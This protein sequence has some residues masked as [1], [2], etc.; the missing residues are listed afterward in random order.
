M[1][2]P[3]ASVEIAGPLPLFD[4]SVEAIQEAG[5]LHLEE[6]P[7]LEDGGHAGLHRIRLSEAQERDRQS[8][9][10]TLRLLEEGVARIPVSLVHDLHGSPK[11]P[12]EYRRWDREN[13]ATLASTVRVLHAKVR[14]QIRRERNLADDLQALSVYEEVSA[15]LAP[16]VDGAALPGELEFVGVV[17]E[18]EARIAADLLEKEVSALSAGRSR[19]FQSV[20][21]GGRVAALVGF[22]RDQEERVRAFMD[23]SGV[24]P[25]AMPRYLR[26]RP[27]EQAL[28]ALAADLAGLRRK[29]QDLAGQALRFYE[30]SG[31]QLLALRDL[32]RDRRTRYEA[33][34]KFA[35]TTYTFLL[36]GWVAAADA[37]RLG[38][39]LAQ[40]AGRAVI[41]RRVRPKGMG[42]PP[43]LL[44][45]P[46]P[47]RSFEPLLSFLPLPQY[48]SVDPT[49]FIA[50]F[51][52]PIFGMMLGDIGYGAILGA[53]AALLWVFGR[54]RP[55]GAAA[56]RTLGRLAVVLAACAFFTVV[57]G[58]VFGELFGSLGHELGLKPLWME[59][60]PQESAEL[61]GAIL[62]YLALAV[63]VGA[64]Q[65]T[66]GL[67]LGVVNARRFRDTDMALGSLA[68]IA[69]ILAVACLVGRLAGVLPAPFAYAGLAAAA[70]FLA[71]MV[72]LVVR[73]P[74]HG[75]ML[76]LEVLG[77]IGN[78]LSYA[79]IMAIGMASVVL[80]V[81]ATVLA[82]L[83]DNVV[84]AALVV[85]A[86]HALNLVLG[87]V[88]PTIQGLR[89]QYVE[90]FP[91]F[92]VTGGKRYSPFRKRGGDIA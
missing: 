88:D 76:P 56:R 75:L 61:G 89:L 83:M 26:G 36:R 92:L 5:L 27:F 48:G 81:L 28:A 46:G 44:S 35:R 3:M 57:F 43:V 41:V 42:S 25:L 22:P 72:M 54:R 78:I 77:T 91:R 86:V 23:R 17:F 12:S 29:R 15:A 60:F 45:N 90:F 62:R 87:T 37:E 47:V 11:L 65:I 33:S 74:A 8:L 19:C 80:A 49:K 84:L 73:H 66:L 63:G 7:L 52:P 30:E 20:L 10:E 69:G 39:M 70:A 24:S 85:V 6:T 38:Q 34:G 55:S 79:R 32:C 4:R 18:R 16:L 31:I 58:F 67:A 51:F 50:T 14:S 64:L 1:I 71:V 59:R 82:R 53:A 21:A 40:K 9:E 68:R 2:T 13:P